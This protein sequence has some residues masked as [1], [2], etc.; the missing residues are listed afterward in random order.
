MSRR[1]RMHR[2]RCEMFLIACSSPV[3]TRPA[4]DSGAE[5]RCLAG[6]LPLRCVEQLGAGSS[7]LASA[8]DT[9]LASLLRPGGPGLLRPASSS[10]ARASDLLPKPQQVRERVRLGPVDS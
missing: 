3:A 10:H 8:S 2:D 6:G 7:E 1:I 5:T 4:P 9:S